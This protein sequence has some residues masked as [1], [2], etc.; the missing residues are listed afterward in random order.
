MLKKI[1]VEIE[2]ICEVCVHFKYK[3]LLPSD[4][5]LCELDDVRV[6]PTDYCILWVLCRPVFNDSPRSYLIIDDCEVKNAN[7]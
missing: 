7:N 1:E 5:Y 6:R 4:G 2:A 3:T